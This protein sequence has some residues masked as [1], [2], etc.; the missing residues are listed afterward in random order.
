MNEAGYRVAYALAG[1]NLQ[2]GNVV[3]ADSV[4][5]I[6]ITRESWRAVAESAGVPFLEVEIVCTDAE[7][8]RRRV[9]TRQSD[10]DGLKLPSWQDVQD[11]EYEAWDKAHLVLDTATL[12]VAECVAAIVW[13]MHRLRG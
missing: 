5:P 9:E 10:I 4:N 7:E 11:R 13:A 6:A 12:S 1:D 8:H 3:I 2:A